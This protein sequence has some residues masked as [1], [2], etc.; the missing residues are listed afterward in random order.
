MAG[1]ASGS[2]NADTTPKPS[3][4]GIWTSRNTRSGLCSR[5]AATASVPLPTSFT[6][7]TSSSSLRSRL[8][9]RRAMG[10]SSTINTRIGMV[11]SCESCGGGFCPRCRKVVCYDQDRRGAVRERYCHEGT[12]IVD[13][14]FGGALPAPPVVHSFARG[15][16]WCYPAHADPCRVDRALGAQLHLERLRRPGAIRF[17]REQVVDEGGQETAW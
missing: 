14:C 8:M 16:R 11:I 5:M 3:R 12:C 10:S 9:R 6:T 7:S 1:I 13:C 17:R 4:S 15:R 2:P